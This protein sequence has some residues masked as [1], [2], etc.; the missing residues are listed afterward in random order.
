MHL[1]KDILLPG[2][3]LVILDSIYLTANKKF[4]EEQVAAVQRVSLQPRLI[5]GVLCYF[6]LIFGLYHFILRTHSSPWNALLLGL[7]IYGVYESTN[8]LAFKKWK[9]QMVVIDTLWG[10][11]LFAL[12]TLIT[13]KFIQ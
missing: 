1:L 8:Y 4:F 11:A 9:W 13:Y 7:V 2:I 12:T 6:F 5:G 10:G 3:I